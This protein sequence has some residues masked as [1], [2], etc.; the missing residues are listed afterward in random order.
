M[1]RSRLIDKGRWRYRVRA[2]DVVPGS[3]EARL[4]EILLCAIV[5]D[6]MLRPELTR[7]KTDRGLV[8]FLLIFTLLDLAY[9]MPCC[10]EE[11]E[12][13]GANAS[14]VINPIPNG[15]SSVMASDH[16][17]P[18]EHSKSDVA[19]E[20]CFCCAHV[21]PGTTP[22]VSPLAVNVLVTDFK[23]NSIPSRP[24][25]SPFHPPRLS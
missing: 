10:I 14:V 17:Q 16:S 22:I 24:P 12:I 13:G 7:K 5:G 9:R 23:D 6:S 25:N 4:V 19:S 8:V 18:E 20:G 2:E 1:H 3:F 15:V 21:L 11:T